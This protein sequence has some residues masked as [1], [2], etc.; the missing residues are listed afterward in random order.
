MTHEV[1][2]EGELFGRRLR[3]V[4]LPS[5]SERF[6]SDDLGRPTPGEPDPLTPRS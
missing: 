6:A 4:R 2:P 3:D 5:R 1:Q